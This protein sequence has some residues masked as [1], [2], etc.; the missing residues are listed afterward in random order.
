VEAQHGSVGVRSTEGVGSVFD[1]L[2]NRVHGTDA[3]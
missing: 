1:L 2:L 3:A